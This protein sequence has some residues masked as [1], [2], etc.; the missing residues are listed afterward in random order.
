[1]GIWKRGGVIFPS[2]P[3]FAD[4]MAR[5]LVA[6]GADA[7]ASYH[8]LCTRPYLD[9]PPDD[10]AELLAM[11]EKVKTPADRADA[12]DALNRGDMKTLWRYLRDAGAY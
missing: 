4:K 6:S 8:A 10:R 7:N 1:M 5:G 12:N 2:D 3:G 11:I 9:I